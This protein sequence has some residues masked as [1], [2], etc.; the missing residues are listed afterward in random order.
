MPPG[1][2]SIAVLCVDAEPGGADIVATRLQRYHERFTTNTATSAR[3]G[4]DHL[5]AADVD[6]IVSDYDIPGADGLEFLETVR[7]EYPA[8]P[9]ILFTGKGSEEIASD[10]ISA[11]ATDYFRRGRD[12]GQYELLANR[13]VNAVERRR[14][15]RARQRQLEAIGTAQ[16]GISILDEDG[17]FLYVN[18]AYADLYGYA[19][20]ELIGEHWELLYPD[21][22]IAFV[23]D[24][25]L[26]TAKTEGR[27]H[28][29]TT[30]LRADGS[31][32]PEE[33]VISGTETGDLVW[34]VEDL[35]E[36]TDLQEK[37]E[38][39]VRASAD[40]FWDWD[41]QTDEITRSGEYLPQ[42]GYVSSDVSTDTDWWRERIHPEDRHR[43]LAALREAVENPETTYDETYRFR[44]KDDTYGHIRSRGYVAY[45]ETGEPKRMVGAHI[46]ITERKEYE[47]ELE[48]QNEQLEEFANVISHDLRNP[49]NVAN[50]RLELAREACKS[51][52][53]DAVDRA[54]DR[55]RTLI[56]DLLTLA[57]EGKQV[58]EVEAIDL[59]AAVDTSWRTVETDGATLTVETE[60]TVRADR[61][62]LQQLLENVIRNAVE[63]GGENVTVT[64]GDLDDGFY[65]ADD[66]SGIPEGER[67][68][69]AGCSTADGGTG[70]GLQI[71][72]QIAEAHGWEIGV[73][74]GDEGGARFEITGVP[75]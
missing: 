56:D 41:P 34:T 38:L 20:E 50:G 10:A 6:C 54:H 14:M 63:H 53:L 70:F 9:F 51:E 4:L 73:T 12:T 55:M 16:E 21:S 19:P 8:L 18:E 47:R 44:K 32:F 74:D 48:R 23:R 65:V 30:G 39:V 31:T 60:R 15:E 25:V 59:A 3:E 66:G 71:V 17:R 64:V 62:R 72:K 67:V 61:G 5:H 1:T 49:L 33:H 57:R 2:S 11:G 43:V 40:A 36:R 28:G 29:T 46:D 58:S 13:I 69:E 24:E 22:E 35:S 45:D 7:E 26:L 37:Y 75:S 68:F 52:H 42:F 27:W